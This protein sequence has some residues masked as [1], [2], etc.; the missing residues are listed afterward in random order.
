M[1]KSL[2]I[3][4]IAILGLLGCSRNQEIDVPDAN[5]SLFARTES[6]ADTKTVVESGVHVFWEPGDEIAVF[7]GEQ[8][9]KFTTDITAASG[10]ATF[11]GTF[12]DATWPEDLDLWA[13]YPFSED[14]VFDG[15]TITTTLPSEQVARDGSFGKDMNLAIAHSSGT[16]LQFYN[17]GGGIRFSVTEEGIKKVM[18]EGLYGEIISGKVKIGMDENGKPVVKEVTGGSQFITLLPPTGQETF[19]PSAWYYIVAIPGSLEG[20]YKLR[21]YKDSDYARKVS[22]KGVEIKRSI[23]G[24]LEK[25][26]E[27]IEYEPQTIHFPTTEEE[28]KESVELTESIQKE[29][30]V[31][32]WGKG[33]EEI[34]DIEAKIEEI[35]MVEGVIYVDTNSAGTCISVVQKDSVCVNYLL[36]NPISRFDDNSGSNALPS[37]LTQSRFHSSNTVANSYFK[38]GKKALVLAPFQWD[39]D[40]RIESV[41]IPELSKNYSPANI[42]YLPDSKAG[43]FQFK[44]ELSKPYDFILIDTHGVT[45]KQS[46]ITPLSFKMENAF[47]ATAT[48]FNLDVAWQIISSDAISTDEVAYV[49]TPKGS[50]YIAINPESLENASYIDNCVIITACESAMMLNNKIPWFDAFTSKGSC[51]VSGATVSMSSGVLGPLADHLIEVMTLGCSFKDA[52]KY[53]VKSQRMRDYCNAVYEL[54][55]ADDDFSSFDIYNNYI[56]KQ[57]ENKPVLDFFLTNPIAF[58]NSPETKAEN[59]YLSWD[60]SS[61]SFPATVKIATS[62]IQQAGKKIKIYDPITFNQTFDVYVDG[63]KISTSCFESGDNTKQIVKIPNPSIGLHSWKVITNIIEVDTG[64]T[65]GSYA[66]EE[67]YFTIVEE[68][69]Y[70]TPEAKDLGLSVKWGSFNLG[71]SKPEMPGVYFAWGETEPYYYRLVPSPVWNDGKEA[72]YDWPSYKWCNGSSSSITKYN[73][74][75]LTQLEPEDDAAHV[76]LDDKWR[77]PTEDEW[78]ELRNNCSFTW[79]TQDGVNGLLVTSLKP[80]YTNVSIFLPAA[81]VVG[82]TSL[83]Y[84]GESGFYWTS[85]NNTSNKENAGYNTFETGSS[86]LG[87]GWIDRCYGLSIRPVYGNPVIPV[88]GDGNLDDI[89]G[90]NI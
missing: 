51:V 57:N 90:H 85:G 9:A 78:A 52:F 24:S 18:F 65:L 64:I 15:E 86:G 71:A 76:N 60:A 12:G 34:S 53:V 17:V 26:D 63:E 35:S 75:A 68:I 7:M 41:W 66:S 48:L 49:S 37:M 44:E 28:C 50:T 16:T 69:K 47:L 1:R 10:T 4:L 70:E 39:F 59:T 25:A 43:V 38:D 21:F 42:R 30:T 20:G 13:V 27:G 79:T 29:V 72:G 84:L 23:F 73:T 33:E 58:L 3:G 62:A 67:D 36:Y 40:K 45:G 87:Y 2:F 19:E 74:S 6:P 89:P 88:D 81:G 31:I 77:I 11:K 80:G 32:L 82:N 54:V 61:Q 5:L 8:S 46:R 14:A 56:Y 83:Y 55:G 22:V